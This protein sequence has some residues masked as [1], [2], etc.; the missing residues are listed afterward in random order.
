MLVRTIWDAGA[1]QSHS[2]HQETIALC[3]QT[4]VKTLVKSSPRAV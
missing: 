3:N 1:R 2:R 4:L